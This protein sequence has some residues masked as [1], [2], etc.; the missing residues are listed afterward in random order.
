MQSNTRSGA[1]IKKRCLGELGGRTAHPEKR[2]IGTVNDRDVELGIVLSG[3]KVK[4]REGRPY[5]CKVVTSRS[6]FRNRERRA[7]CGL[8]CGTRGRTRLGSY[9]HAV[10]LP[11]SPATGREVRL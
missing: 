3:W 5:S 4:S 8:D 9:E 1:A 10:M 2:M 7:P 11:G 6:N